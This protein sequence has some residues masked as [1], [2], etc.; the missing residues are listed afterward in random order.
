MSAGGRQGEAGQRAVV[1]R[2]YQPDPERCVRAVEVLLRPVDKK[3]DTRVRRS[4]RG[5]KPG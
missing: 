5:S 4:S 1:S 2:E 3:A